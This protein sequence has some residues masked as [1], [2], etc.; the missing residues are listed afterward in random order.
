MTLLIMLVWFNKTLGE[1]VEAA[2]DR[3]IALLRLDCDW[4]DSPRSCLEH[5]VTLVPKGGLIIVDDNYAWD[6]CARAVHDY[7][8]CHDLLYGIRSLPNWHGAY[9]IKQQHRQRFDVL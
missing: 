6:G 9:F 3:S 7:L 1:L 2:Q 8:S 5:L 4:H